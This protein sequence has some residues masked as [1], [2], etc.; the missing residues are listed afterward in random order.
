M[1]DVTTK[2]A[3][4]KYVGILGAAIGLGMIV[5][6]AVGGV[7]SALYGYAAPSFLASAL[8]FSNF[9]AAYFRLPEPSTKMTNTDSPHIGLTTL[10]G[11]LRRKAFVLLLPA[12]FVATVAFVFENA[13]ASP[14]LQTTFHYG[15]F[16]VGLIFAY[17][18]VLYAVTQGV[19]VPMLSKR[20]AA[21]T[22]VLLGLV[23]TT[24]AYVVLGAFADVQVLVP[25]AGLLTIGFGLTAPT[26]SALISLN[27]E[28][29]SQGGALGA[30]ASLNGLAQALT[31]GLAT[32]I[33]SFGVSLGM[34]GF[35]M[36]AAGGVSAVALPVILAFARGGYPGTA[37]LLPAARQG[38]I[39]VGE[40]GRHVTV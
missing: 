40:A 19:L 36:V 21:T 17:S 7:L 34:N 8:A 3:R 16:Q 23:S 25:M 30:A 9:S 6:P 11:A 38:R 22:I 35:V 4:V 31:P 20:M 13:V 33:F 39:A 32:S 1:A 28:V 14:W 26:L 27:A 37:K 18:G 12:T 5:G 2:E 10:I 24:V 15:P 29:D